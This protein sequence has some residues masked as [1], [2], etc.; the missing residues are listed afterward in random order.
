MSCRT[1]APDIEH[2]LRPASLVD[3]DKLKPVTAASGSNM[4]AQALPDVVQE[5][6]IVV[7]PQDMPLVFGPTLW[8]KGFLPILSSDASHASPAAPVNFRGSSV[9]SSIAATRSFSTCIWRT[10]HSGA[11][12]QGASFPLFCRVVLPA[13][14]YGLRPCRIRPASNLFG[15]VPRW[16][17]S[18]L[19]CTGFPRSP[20]SRFAIVLG[21]AGIRGYTGRSL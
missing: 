16:F 10:A 15:A 8:R 18:S 11:V 19:R 21:F 13:S 2:A 14:M 5:S 9:P 20:T 3:R 12:V 4:N 6:V 17:R 1:V 7:S